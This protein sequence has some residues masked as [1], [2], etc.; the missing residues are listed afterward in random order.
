M[1]KIIAGIDIG[2]TNVRIAL[3]K[4]GNPSDILLKRNFRTPV[5]EGPQFF[6]QKVEE[7]LTQCLGDLDVGMDELVGIGC[8][9]PGIT[10]EVTGT[11]LFVSNLKGW[12]G[13]PVGRS[14]KERFGLE[15]VVENDVN[16]AALGEYR[17]G[18]GAGA[19]SLVYFTISTGVAAGIV[20]QGAIW[21]GFNHA[22]GELAF[23]IPDPDHIGQDW[24]PN[25]C[26]ELMSAG[27]GLAR[28]WRDAHHGSDQ[29]VTA[30][31]VFE[32]LHD[33]DEKARL[34]VERAAKYLAQSV[35]AIC[36]LLNPQVV[37]LSG[38]IA[39]HQPIFLDRIK[40]VV[41]HTV[42][43]P[44]EIVLSELEGDAPLVG[45]LALI[46]DVEH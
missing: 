21:R 18:V 42:P 44:A 8:A 27:V 45:A 7:V 17:F 38:S 16:A 35:V 40:T 33:G 1:Q 6:I 4:K 28:L 23:F 24:S 29:S 37:V 30:I 14:F 32:A 2:G 9:L 39:Q 5:D 13:F 22:A 25:G 3:A 10:D 43:H 26:L 20:L 34:I 19:H 11:A 15:V 36:A 12:D 41:E 31:D 46:D